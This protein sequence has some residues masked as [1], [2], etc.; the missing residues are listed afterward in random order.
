[1][2]FAPP[3]GEPP[4]HSRDIGEGEPIQ[5]IHLENSGVISFGR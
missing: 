3:N 1:M 4:E 2:G 5:P